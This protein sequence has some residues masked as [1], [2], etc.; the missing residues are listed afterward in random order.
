MVLTT[1]HMQERADSRPIVSI[2]LTKC[3]YVVELARVQAKNTRKREMNK[4]S[5]LCLNSLCH[6][7]TSFY[8]FVFIHEI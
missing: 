6:A 5:T 3:N 2:L 7:P 4:S 8:E 1:I